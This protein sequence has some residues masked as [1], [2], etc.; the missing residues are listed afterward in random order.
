[1]IDRRTGQNNNRVE[2]LRIA[3]TCGV[4]EKWRDVACDYF[5]FAND[6]DDVDRIE[7]ALRENRPEFFKKTK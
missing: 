1:M 6:S 7:K 3:H 5:R 2:L 4:V